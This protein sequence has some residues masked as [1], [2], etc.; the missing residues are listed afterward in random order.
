MHRRVL[1][2]DRGELD[3]VCGV[4]AG[5]GLDVFR[6]ASGAGPE[7]IPEAALLVAGGV[8]P[9]AASAF[10]ARARHS[11]WITGAGVDAS[12]EALREL[13]FAYR[14]RRPVHLE[15]LRLFFVHLLFEGEDRRSE[16]RTPIGVQVSATTGSRWE[17]ATLLDLS[18][19]GCRLQMTQ[20]PEPGD[21]VEIALPLL[22][23]SHP[24]LC[25]PGRVTRVDWDPRLA[26][27]NLRAA[28]VSFDDLD[29]DV[30]ASLA[31]M[32]DEFGA[33]PPS[34]APPEAPAASRGERRTPRARFH[35]KV[36][37][38]DDESL[39]LLVARDLSTGGMRVAPAP[40]VH[41]GDRLHVAVYGDPHEEPLVL[42]ATVLRDDGPEGLALGFDRLDVQATAFIERVIEALPRLDRL[43]ADDGRTLVGRIL[44]D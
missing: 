24:R 30:R 4:L 32:L 25:L 40:G 29:E 12:R 18:A 43:D 44:G 33:V 14:V 22:A 36:P 1:V 35:R 27:R 20:P 8:E 2:L 3:D 19:R 21:T 41:L 31:A 34:E 10:T 6:C 28:A 38:F 7:A 13:G 37:A 39:R 42:W 16:V 15:A 9:Q 17:K 11:V 26:T 23:P 5:L